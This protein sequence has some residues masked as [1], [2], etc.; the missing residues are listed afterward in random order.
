MSAS[1]HVQRQITGRHVL[2]GM[3]AFFAIV[4]CAN[5]ALVY[6]AQSSFNGLAEENAYEKGLAWNEAL[7]QQKALDSA[8]W[9]AEASAVPGAKE[10]RIAL[11][12]KNGPAAGATGEVLYFRPVES[13]HDLRAPL[14]PTAEPGIYRAAADLPLP[15][16][17]EVRVSASYKDQKFDT[18]QR[19]RFPE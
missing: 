16:L 14:E 13:G 18:A 19:M 11:S 8:G 1:P 6:V 15:G 5:V 2:L 10:I 7:A 17:W 12:D 4:L 3:L 9:R